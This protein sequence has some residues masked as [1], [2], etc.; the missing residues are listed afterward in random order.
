VDKLLSHGGGVPQQDGTF[1]LF[2]GTVDEMIS[3]AH[4]WDSMTRKQQEF[5]MQQAEKLFGTFLN[6]FI[7][8]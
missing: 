8:R 1:A 3:R 7:E 6:T 4:D 5:F 2:K